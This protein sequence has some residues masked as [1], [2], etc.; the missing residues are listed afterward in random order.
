MVLAEKK[1][2]PSH[3]L[4]TIVKNPKR[5]VVI[6]RKLLAKLAKRG[7]ILESLPYCHYDYKLV[8]VFI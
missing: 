6:R 8:N 2:I 1:I 4:E 7:Q 3:K 5:G